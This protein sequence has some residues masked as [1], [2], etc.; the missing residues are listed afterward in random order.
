MQV[1]FMS[2]SVHT[3]MRTATLSLKLQIKPAVSSSDRIP[4]PGQ[5]FLA[6]TLCLTMQRYQFN[7]TGVTRLGK[8]GQ[9][10]IG[11]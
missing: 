9:L 5:P 7:V 4:L 3:I 6:P 2:R 1:Y 8:S 11:V 10:V